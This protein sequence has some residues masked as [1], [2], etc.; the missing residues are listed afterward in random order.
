MA[1]EDSESEEAASGGSV[2][3]NALVQHVLRESYLQ[4]TEDLR[5]YAE[6]VREF[7]KRKKAMREYLST[8]RQVKADVLW[9]AFDNGLDLCSYDERSRAE[10]AKL[11]EERSVQYP[12]SRVAHELCIPN[13]APPKDANSIELIEAEIR[14]WEERMAMLNGDSQLANVDLQSTLQK[15]QQALQMMSNTSKLAHDTAMRIIGNIGG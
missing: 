15:Q 13:L 14:R 6:K 4:T 10:L 2:D 3:P 8:L 7:N 1:S 12:R 11:I 9:K 5:F